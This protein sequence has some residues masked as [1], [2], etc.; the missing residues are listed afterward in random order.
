[1]KQRESLPAGNS[2]VFN[3]KDMNNGVLTE[4][5]QMTVKLGMTKQLPLPITINSLCVIGQKVD[6]IQIYGN[7]VGIQVTENNDIFKNRTENQNQL[8]SN[9][10]SFSVRTRTNS[11][12]QVKQNNFL[13][14]GDCLAKN[15]FSRK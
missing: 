2:S 7:N 6:E 8:T 14:R 9:R 1:M 5:N 11:F 13:Q 3:K 4:R 12:L 15:F 10:K